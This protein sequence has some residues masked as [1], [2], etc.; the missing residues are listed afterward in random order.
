MLTEDEEELELT[1]LDDE[2]EREDED[3]DE[4]I[5]DDDEEVDFVVE[6]EV[7][8]VV[9]PIK[10]GRNIPAGWYLARIRIPTR[11]RTFC[12]LRCFLIRFLIFTFRAVALSFHE[13]LPELLPSGVLVIPG[14]LIALLDSIANEEVR[15]DIVLIDL[16]Q[17]SRWDAGVVHE[18]VRVIIEVEDHFSL[19]E[20]PLGKQTEAVYRGGKY[21][22]IPHIGFG[23]AS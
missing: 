15:A 4:E 12:Q 1:L 2:V 6:L 5:E 23:H 13:V 10:N 8:V 11:R 3:E 18:P 17:D 9:F 14:Y 20:V 7:E 21:L 16:A 19:F 22:E